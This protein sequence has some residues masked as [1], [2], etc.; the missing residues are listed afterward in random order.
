M[1]EE[2]LISV[3]N[4]VEFTNKTGLPYNGSDV[5]IISKLFAETRINWDIS[6]FES[7]KSAGPDNITPVE[8]CSF[9]VDD[10]L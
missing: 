4:D 10:Y 6:S 7:Y 8:T 2:S 9:L 1:E 3:I 5:D